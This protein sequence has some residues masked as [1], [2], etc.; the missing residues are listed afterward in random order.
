[1]LVYTEKT[2]RLGEV[3]SLGGKCDRLGGIAIAWGECDRLGGIAI[4]W[5]ELRS[6]LWGYLGISNFKGNN[7]NG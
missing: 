2:R 1:M 3:R 4:A 7:G 5:G 6:H